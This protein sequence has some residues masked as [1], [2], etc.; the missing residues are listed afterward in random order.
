MPQFKVHTK[1][2][3]HAIYMVEAET[4]KEAEEKFDEGL[5]GSPWFTETLDAEV[6]CVEDK[7]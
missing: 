1:E 3:V 7:E 6:S 2:T 5:A 4:W